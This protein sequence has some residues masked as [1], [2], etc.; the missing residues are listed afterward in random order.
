MQISPARWII[1]G[2]AESVFA[3][4]IGRRHWRG[5]ERAEAVEGAGAQ[6]VAAAAIRT[7]ASEFTDASRA[8]AAIEIAAAVQVGDAPATVTVA[9][10]ASPS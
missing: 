5:F 8:A 2:R 9:S 4:T 6:P 3:L 1:Q 10:L 7:V